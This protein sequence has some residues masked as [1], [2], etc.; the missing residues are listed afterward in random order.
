MTR[1]AS[2]PV[3]LG[4]TAP[5]VDLPSEYVEQVKRMLSFADDDLSV[6]PEPKPAF[7]IARREIGIVGTINEIPALAANERARSWFVRWRDEAPTYGQLTAV[8]D[9]L[10]PRVD[11]V[12]VDLSDLK[13]PAYHMIRPGSG[14]Q[15]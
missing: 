6:Q 1:I 2:V 9:I 8:I 12:I 7:R 4:T 14:G 5:P 11:V 3:L 10:G 15:A 13:L